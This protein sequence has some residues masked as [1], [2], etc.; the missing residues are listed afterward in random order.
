MEFASRLIV[1]GFGIWMIGVSGLIFMRPDFA[2]S[3]LRKFASTHLINYTE[4]GF[5]LI[6]GLGFVGLAPQTN[7]AVALKGIGIFLAATA[8]ILMLVPR[9]WHHKYAVWWA[10]KL[11]H[12]QVR[13]CAPFSFVT[14]VFVTILA[15]S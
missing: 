14:G 9:V 15:V 13:F 7:Y 8:L 12:G 1:I 11:T 10:D 2:L 6:V 5:R 4:L 3:S